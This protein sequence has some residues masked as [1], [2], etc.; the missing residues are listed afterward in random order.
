MEQKEKNVEELQKELKLLRGENIKLL[1]QQNQ[2]K[3]Q[4]SK[5]L[6]VIEF[7]TKGNE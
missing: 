3:K 5:L 7:L 1:T 6:A 2:L 4:V